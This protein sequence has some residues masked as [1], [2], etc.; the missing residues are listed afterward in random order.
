MMN[1]ATQANARCFVMGRDFIGI[2]DSGFGI[3]LESGPAANPESRPRS[4]S[5]TDSDL[6]LL[7]RLRAQNLAERIGE[8]IVDITAGAWG[9]Q[10]VGPEHIED[11]RNELQLAPIPQRNRFADPR[12]EAVVAVAVELAR[13]D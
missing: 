11:L 10:V 6:A 4:E 12:I 5:V 13:A 3:R 2:R 7:T 8:R 1:A 9:K